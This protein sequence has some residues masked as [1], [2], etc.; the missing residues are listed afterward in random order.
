MAP[1]TTRMV[2][3]FWVI[4]TDH[5]E[6]MKEQQL[7]LQPNFINSRKQKHQE[8]WCLWLYKSCFRSKEKW[9]EKGRAQ[10]GSFSVKRETWILG[11]TG[12]SV[13]PSLKFTFTHVYIYATLNL[14]RK[15]NPTWFWF[16][17]PFIY[18]RTSKLKPKLTT[19]K[20]TCFFFWLKQNC[21]NKE[22]H[23]A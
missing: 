22:C 19:L 4:P 15:L 16:T 17:I 2:W 6:Q 13:L 21:G 7:P 9:N 20:T 23:L 14:K 10:V 18:I 8:S 11:N 3:R 12:S 5:I 1:N